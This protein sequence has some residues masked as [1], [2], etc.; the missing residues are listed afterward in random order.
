MRRNAGRRACACV[1]AH[2]CGLRSGAVLSEFE[3]PRHWKAAVLSWCSS[4][5]GLERFRS[6]IDRRGRQ[7]A[8]SAVGSQVVLVW[9]ALTARTSAPEHSAAADMTL[10]ATS[11]SLWR[12][13]GGGTVTTYGA[14][15]AAAAGI[16]RARPA[17]YLITALDSVDQDADGY[18]STTVPSLASATSSTSCM[19][20]CSMILEQIDVVPLVK[21]GNLPVSRWPAVRGAQQPAAPRRTPSTTCALMC[22]CVGLRQLSRGHP[23]HRRHRRRR[24]RRC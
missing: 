8:V 24:R 6:R 16:G 4:Q 13:V 3:P 23:F 9:P 14:G 20:P 15:D 5:V 2:W 18:A 7:G 17:D 11:P 12:N 19:H 21:A 22:A 10:C 1:C